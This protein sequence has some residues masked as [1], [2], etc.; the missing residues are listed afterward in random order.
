MLIFLPYKGAYLYTKSFGRLW[1][2]LVI[3]SASLS[4]LSEGFQSTM[5]LA[6]VPYQTFLKRL[7][8]LTTVCEVRGR[9]LEFLLVL[10]N[11]KFKQEDWNVSSLRYLGNANST[12]LGWD[13]WFLLP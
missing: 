7:N 9:L 10:Y 4:C 6:D 11:S 2:H 12:K 3:G 13:T 5:F 1:L 8:Y